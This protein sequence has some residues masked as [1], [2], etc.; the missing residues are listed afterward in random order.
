MSV[1]TSF[2][3]Y[4]EAQSAQFFKALADRAREVPGVVTVS[5][6]TSVPMWNDTLGAEPVVPE[7]DSFPQGKD[8]ATVFMSRID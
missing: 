4:T 7:G 3:H 1:D 2:G 5:L 6:T 8:N